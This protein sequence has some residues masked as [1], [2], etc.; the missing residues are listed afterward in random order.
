MSNNFEG[1]KEKS[2][3][4]VATRTIES[5][6]CLSPKLVVEKVLATHKL[7]EIE[8]SVGPGDRQ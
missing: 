4:K 7:V 1:Q 5:R 8:L 3:P 2:K 6:K